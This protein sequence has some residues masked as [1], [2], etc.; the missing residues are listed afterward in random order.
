MNPADNVA[1]AVAD[2]NQ[3]AKLT[4]GDT[5]LIT[6]ED[7]PFGHKVALKPIATDEDIIKY[8][9]PIGIATRDI[10]V[11]EWVHTHNVETKLS[12]K[13]EYVYA[14]APPIGV[15]GVAENL[16]FQGYRREEGSV[17]TRNE[18][19]ILPTV[20]CVN[21]IGTMIA[22]RAAEELRKQSW[23]TSLDGVFEFKHPYGC[24]QLGDDHHKTQRILAALSR[25]PNAGGV[26]MLSLGC[27]NNNVEEFTKVLGDY[28]P[29]RVHFLITQDVEDEV[30]AGVAHVMELARRAARVKR[31]TVPVS[32]LRVGLKCGGSD[33]FSG[34]TAN[35]LLGV[36][37]DRIVAAGGTT[38]LTEV[39]EM[40]GAEHL[41]MRRANNRDVFAN[42]VQ[43]INEFKEYFISHN[44]PIYENPSIGNKAGGI[45]T[46]EDKS[47]G[48]TQKGGTMPVVDV[49]DYADPV[50]LAGL[51]LLSS[52]GNDGVAS[53]ALAASG[54]QIV[55]FTTGRGTPFGTCVPTMKIA[56]NTP[57]YNKKENWMDFNA[58]VILEG[59]TMEEAADQFLGRIL[60]VAS[61]EEAKNERMGF[62]ELVI[63]KNGVTV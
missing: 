42:I 43:M 30:E 63:F 27:E 55:L 15:T 44:Q 19:W 22:R 59:V 20:N 37:S 35:P 12:G 9:D 54:C 28:D 53:T 3:G 1:V 26:L 51:N 16:T 52:P 47:L 29:N 40:F 21:Q 48:C 57:L 38:V 7:I 4:V 56:T 45:T 24:S 46:L 14:G 60:A 62:R 39:P 13:L 11:G 18:I 61:G 8:A 36:V 10:A 25:H 32:E 17:G 41:L 2:L 31:E 58:G 34:I 6:K 23:A 5:T 33:G 49:V 50:R